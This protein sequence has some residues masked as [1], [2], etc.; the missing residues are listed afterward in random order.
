MET[1]ARGY[2]ILVSHPIVHVEWSWREVA[3]SMTKEPIRLQK[4]VSFKAKTADILGPS[5]NPAAT[6]TQNHEVYL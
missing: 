4:Y 1:H 6:C 5:P 2:G 3:A